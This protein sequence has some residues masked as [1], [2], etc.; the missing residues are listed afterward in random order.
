MKVQ[1]REVVKIVEV[2]REVTTERWVRGNLSLNDHKEIF[3]VKILRS[4]N[5]FTAQAFKRVTAQINEHCTKRV[6]SSRT[7]SDLGSGR[8]FPAD[9]GQQ[10]RICGEAGNRAPACR[11]QEGFGNGGLSVQV[12]KNGGVNP[13]GLGSAWHATGLQIARTCLRYAFFIDRPR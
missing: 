12:G 2:E 11:R 8:R 10:G 9:V 3:E 6:I 13:S 4:Q 7:A 5:G 1:V